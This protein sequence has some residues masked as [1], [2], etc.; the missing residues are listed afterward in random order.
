MAV[1]RSSRYARTA[2]IV[3][4]RPDGA[5]VEL[6]DLRETP[7]ATGVFYATPRP[8][9]RLDLLAHRYYRDPLRFWRICDASPEMDPFDVVVPGE[10]LLV[11]PSK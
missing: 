5:A 7:A 10:R 3:V 6:L 9:D 4:T 11:P 8:G 1:D 2:T